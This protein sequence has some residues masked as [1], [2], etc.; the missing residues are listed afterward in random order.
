MR[1][2][3]V[4]L[5]PVACPKANVDREKALWRLTSAGFEAV[6]DAQDADLVV[7]FTCGFIDDAKQEAIDDILTYAALKR[8]GNVKGIAVVGCLPEKY[9][10]ELSRE[11]PEVDAFVG[12]T[13]IDQLPR[14]LAALTS[15]PPAE[16]LLRGGSFDGARDLSGAG[17]RALP[18]SRPWT[19]MLMVSDGCS[20]ACTY[21]AIPHMRGPLRSRPVEEII[22][23]AMMLVR[24]GAKEI[25]LAGQDTASYGRDCGTAG[26]AALISRI[27]ETVEVP[28][29][30]LAY[31]NPET[32]EPDVALVM[33]DCPRVCHYVDMPIQHA[34]ARVLSAM[35]RSKGPEAIRRAVDNLRKAVPD[36]ALRTS[37]IVGFPGETEADFKIL[38]RFLSEVEFDLVG[39]FKFS[40]QPGTPAAALDNK[41][42]A[43]VADQRLLEVTCQAHNI[44]RSK[45]SAIIGK[46][47]QVLV[48]ERGRGACLGRSQYDMAEV[49]RVVKLVGC[50]APPGDF[51]LARP[52]R[53][54]GDYEIEAVCLE[55]GGPAG[56]PGRGGQPDSA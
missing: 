5:S 53:C 35:G 41:V 14:V 24:Q 43:A 12:N 50:A 4:H 30:R 38:V 23:E 45:I 55:A 49:D 1:Q 22:G 15:G 8:R 27:G 34:S 10:E 11:M 56:S 2:T 13:E 37:V 52:R 39:V 20:N 48:E 54:L 36:V 25:V 44:A 47:L 21:C 33:R 18:P 19:R 7:V 3:R 31:A 40:P 26:L 16:R 28:W 29:I 42:P 32:L 51:V 6:D 46:H 17:G 9:G